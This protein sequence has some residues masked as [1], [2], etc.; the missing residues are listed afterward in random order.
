ML[1]LTQQTSSSATRGRLY[2]PCRAFICYSS[3]IFTTIFQLFFSLL[4]CMIFVSRQ[5]YQLWYTFVF[6]LAIRWFYLM[7]ANKKEKYERALIGVFGKLYTIFKKA[8][9]FVF[10]GYQE[11]FSGLSRTIFGRSK[12]D[13]LYQSIKS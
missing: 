8:I 10:G 4:S 12:N 13:F 11:R 7:P 5:H 1:S 3:S 2:Q 6:I 9:F